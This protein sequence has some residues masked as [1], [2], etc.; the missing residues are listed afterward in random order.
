MLRRLACFCVLS[1][2]A[3]TTPAV[4]AQSMLPAT[5]PAT[6]PATR[7]A[8]AADQTTP[9]GTLIL[10]AKAIQEG[11]VPVVRGIF[12]ATS[13]Q[14]NTLADFFS[15]R[16]KVSADFRSAVAGK[17]GEEAAERLTNSSAE[18]VAIAAQH[19]SDAEV[20]V[21]G[22][23]AVVQMKSEFP[24]A[25]APD[26][27]ELVRADGKWKVPMGAMTEGLTPDKIDENV[28]MLKT[29]QDVIVKMTGEVQQGKY[30][31]IEEVV[32]ALNSR[33][34]SAALEMAP[35][36]SAPSTAPGMP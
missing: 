26:A 17:F 9:Q 23:K 3:V 10:F 7:P 29:M 8:I 30:S 18:D 25:P 4:F 32:D 21:D 12:H 14:E 11:D 28:K 31:K 20:K 19:I 1:A 24:G 33:L 16:T 27:I 5:A 22:D 35:P 15:E 36:T 2:V 13:P 34:Q 6:A